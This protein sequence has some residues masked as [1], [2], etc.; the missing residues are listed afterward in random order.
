MPE[1]VAPRRTVAKATPLIRKL[2]VAIGIGLTLAALRFDILEQLQGVGANYWNDRNTRSLLVVLIAVCF[3]FLVTAVLLENDRYLAPVSGFGAILLGFFLFIPGA[4]GFAHLGDLGLGANLA[5]AGSALI[6]LGALPTKALFSWRRSRE[7]YSLRLY[8]TWLTAAVGSGIVIVSLGRQITAFVIS[9]PTS[10]GLTGELP[11]YWTSAGFAGGHTLGALM[12]VLAVL[13]IVFA[14]LDGLLR[15]PVFGSWA[16]AV[17]LPLLGLMLYYPFS[18][19]EIGN[20]S[21]GGGLGLEGAALAALASLAAVGVERG[22]IE[23]SALNLRRLAAI[24]GIGLA[25]AGTYT[26]HFSVPGTLWSED[27]TLAGLPTILAFLAAGILIFSFVSARRWLLPAVSV[28]GWIV[29]GY[30]GYSLAWIMPQTG[31]LGPAVW[32]GVA[33]GAL[34]GLSALSLYSRAAWRRRLPNIGRGRL[35]AWLSVAVG[36]CIAL[37]SLWLDTEHGQTQSGKL[38]LLSYWSLAGDHSLG[39]VMLVL[40]VSTLL[41]LLALLITRFAVLSTWVLAAS[42]TLLGISLLLPAIAAFGHLGSLHSGAWLALVGSLVAGAGA[43]ALWL[44][45]QMEAKVESNETEE[46]APGRTRVAPKGKRRVPEMRR[47][48]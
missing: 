12:L 47:A 30:F 45:Y 23:A 1:T 38:V 6:V 14:A 7:R 33:G 19:N 18:I 40:A 13:V 21:I 4:I 36:I 37:V 8:L 27:S 44:P 24:I 5:V 29:F 10:T 17:S 9:S 42:L 3:G 20:L 46:A 28:I 32:L 11:R 22:T 35:L 31:L 25:L 41:A 43:V 2:V 26:N 34:M 48:K 15:A 16:L 39:I